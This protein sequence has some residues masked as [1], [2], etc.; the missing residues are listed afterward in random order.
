MPLNVRFALSISYHL[1]INF[2]LVD[3]EKLSFCELYKYSKA[4]SNGLFF[5]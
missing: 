5:F 2:T 1:K 4:I 3:I